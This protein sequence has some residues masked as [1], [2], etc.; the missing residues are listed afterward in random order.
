MR[1][2]WYR[3]NVSDLSSCILIKVRRL[4]FI[5]L[6]L[7]SDN[8]LRT[9]ESRRCLAWGTIHPA[10]L[11]QYYCTLVRLAVG[12]SVKGVLVSVSAL[13][14]VA[15]VVVVVIVVVVEQPSAPKVMRSNK[16]TARGKGKLMHNI[17]LDG[18]TLRTM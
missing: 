18:L 10:M 12:W 9:N 7:V 1:S 16:V 2:L 17:L 15:A 11:L 6:Y 14:A 3:T 4:D 8:G 13:I 5:L